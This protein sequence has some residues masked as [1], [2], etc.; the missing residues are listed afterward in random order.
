MTKRNRTCREA[1]ERDRHQYATGCIK[2]GWQTIVTVSR[3]PRGR[4]DVG[5]RLRYRLVGALV[6]SRGAVLARTCRH[7]V[8]VVVMSRRKG[9]HNY[10]GDQVKRDPSNRQEGISP[11]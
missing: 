1:D 9:D 4:C 3:F 10:C 5:L 11:S 6:S 2:F 8:G 7:E